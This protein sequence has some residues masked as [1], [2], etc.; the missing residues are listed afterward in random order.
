M[1]KKAVRAKKPEPVP[2]TPVAPVAPIV[3]EPE[4]QVETTRA[5]ELVPPVVP[6][7]E[8]KPK[9][10]LEPVVEGG[11]PATGELKTSI[12]SLA[13]IVDKPAEVKPEV[14]VEEEEE[15]S[16]RKMGGGFW[17]ALMFVVGVGLGVL[18]GYVV[19]AKPTLWPL[20][21]LTKPAKTETT[22]QVVE[23]TVAV[24]TTPTPATESGVK[25]EEVKIKV[26][27]GTG[28][29]GIAAIAKTYLEGLGY[30][31]ITTGNAVRND[32][33][34]TTVVLSETKKAFWTTLK[35]DLA[36]KYQVENDYDTDES[37]LVKHDGVDAL[38]IIGA[39]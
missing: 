18:A 19:W 38:V 4:V 26:L 22:A 35:A 30:K 32:Y 25:R 7:A 24:E 23:P 13:G 34:T 1:P 11:V 2:E 10:I 28:T 31:D 14:V 37:L 8:E 16:G 27:N 20:P 3:I 17:M 9:V 12:D 5:P 36:S 33:E 39:K 21:F 6:V 29:K 15:K